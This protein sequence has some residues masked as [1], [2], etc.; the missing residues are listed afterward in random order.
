MTTLILIL[1]ATF[2]GY[3]LGK[4]A[5]THQA[6]PDLENTGEAIVNALLKKHFPRPYHYLF[7]N[8]TLP[9]SKK[10]TTQI[11]HIL[12]NQY[13]LFVIETKHYA[14]S[15]Y[16]KKDE[17][18]WTQ[19]FNKNQTFQFLNP[20]VQNDS[21]IRHLKKQL[22]HL[23][24][25][26]F[27]SIIVFTGVAE[28]KSPPILNVLQTQNLLHYLRQASDPILSELDIEKT[29]GRLEL[30]RKE[31]SKET[32]AAHIEFVQNVK[33]SNRFNV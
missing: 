33:K 11:D 26:A 27:K 32:D 10:G 23:P 31:P 19:V 9:I 16:G 4:R 21:H 28:L 18:Q 29:I 20:L 2:I 5:T 6:I 13:G 17:A 25:Q 15:I 14:G 3:Q 8:V 22:P 7:H 24:A 30:N 1:I 12:I